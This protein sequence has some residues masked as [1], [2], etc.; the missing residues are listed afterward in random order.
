MEI[1]FRINSKE[2]DSKFW[3]AIR[4]LFAD[5]DVEVSIKA[6]V[7]ETDF[8]LSNPATKR[9]LLKSIKNVEENKNLV[10]FTGEEFLKMTK[11]LS[12]A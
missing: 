5:K 12:K 10:H 7:N 6:S 4:L 3:K 11:K 8:L 2:I 9:K 1:V